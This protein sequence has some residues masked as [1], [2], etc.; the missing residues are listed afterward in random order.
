MGAGEVI[1][2]VMVDKPIRRAVDIQADDY[3]IKIE[4]D[5]FLVGCGLDLAGKFRNLPEILALDESELL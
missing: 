2:V 5:L 4:E 1:V 3:V